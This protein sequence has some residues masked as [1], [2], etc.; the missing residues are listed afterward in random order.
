MS[1]KTIKT[2]NIPLF[3][4]CLLCFFVTQCAN[5]EVIPNETDFFQDVM[6]SRGN[7]TSNIETLSLSER[8]FGIFEQ[9]SGSN[10]YKSITFEV[11]LDQ[12]SIMPLMS[13]D[14]VGGVIVTDWYSTTSNI[15]ERVK[16]NVIIKNDNMNNES[17]DI[18]MFK[19]N[20]NGTTWTKT[21]VDTETTNKIKSVILEKSKKF[22]ATLELS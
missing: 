15:N 14:R 22:K 2:N 13:V 9:E 18:I 21:P 12:F 4:V 17:I 3:I 8:L 20:Y 11:V 7:D 6:E 19:Q 5:L 10:L 16:F 1:I